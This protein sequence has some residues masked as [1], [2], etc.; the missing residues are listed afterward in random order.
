MNKDKVQRTFKA[1]P[2]WAWLV[3]AGAGGALYWWFFVRGKNPNPDPTNTGSTTWSGT[4]G[5]STPTN[6]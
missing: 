5:F 2:W 1:L 4:P 3:I 6:N